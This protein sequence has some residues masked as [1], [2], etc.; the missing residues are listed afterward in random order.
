MIRA[1]VLGSPI[2][3]SLSPLIHTKAYELLG[4]EGSYER[5]DVGVDQFEEFIESS[6]SQ[7]WTGFS[8]TMPLKES[9]FKYDFDV[10]SRSSKIQSANTLIR[11]GSSYR[12]LST[13]VS[14]FDRILTGITF[15]EVLLIGGGGTARAALGALDGLVEKITIVQRSDAR[16]NQLK[17][18][19]DSSEL[20]FVD[21][22]HQLN[23][24][25]LVISTTPQGVSDIFAERVN[26]DVKT[27][28]EVLYKPSPTKLSEAWLK[29]GGNVINGLD[30]LVEQALDQI[31][32]MTGAS[33]DYAWMRT[34]LLEEVRI[35][36]S[37]G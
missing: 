19:V 30:L 15:S 31:H 21:F 34:A 9:A 29:H 25:D 18:C 27:L 28:I 36:Q 13:D 26:S 6:L 22:S 35:R 3:H 11:E 10:D 32:L 12:V 2:Q 5:F 37:Q 17:A 16:N 8:M 23:A 1:A 4:I 7:S 20:N 24:Y 14:A 33:F